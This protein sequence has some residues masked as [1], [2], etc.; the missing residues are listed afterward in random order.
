MKQETQHKKWDVGFKKRDSGQILWV[1]SFGENITEATRK[2]EQ[3]ISKSHPNEG[4]RLYAGPLET[5]EQSK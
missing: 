2:A 5:K 3:F 4:Y 1:Y